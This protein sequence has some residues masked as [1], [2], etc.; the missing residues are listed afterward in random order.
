MNLAFQSLKTV[1]GALLLTAAVLPQAGAQTAPDQNSREAARRLAK[2]MCM[3]CHGEDGVSSKPLVP[4]IAGQQRAYLEAQLKA[5]RRQN[6]A[7]PEAHDYMWGIAATLDDNV[8]ASL[9]DYY[10]KLPPAKGEPGDAALI[11]EGKTLFER[12]HDDRGV[13]ACTVCHGDNAEGHSVFPRL[14]GQH[15]QYLARQMQ[16]L[17]SRLRDSPVMHGVTKDLADEE[18]R[19][20][21]MYLQ[22]R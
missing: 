18:I 10:S 6:R 7:D 11:A 8:V 17:R 1:L 3:S 22:A 13:P 15:G 12:G 9:A 2:G 21:A 14:A 19:A 4:R 5:F 16:L 20:L